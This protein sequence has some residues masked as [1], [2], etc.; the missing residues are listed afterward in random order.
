MVTLR[1]MKRQSHT[2]NRGSDGEKPLEQ[3][4]TKR[5]AEFNLLE[6]G[7]GA[8]WTAGESQQPVPHVGLCPL[9]SAAIAHPPDQLHR[10]EERD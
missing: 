9:S 1:A 10:A 8:A 3:A 4:G 5:K 7:K 2:A 6:P